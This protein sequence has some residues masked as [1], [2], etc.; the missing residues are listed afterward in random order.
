MRDRVSLASLTVA[1]VVWGGL[2]S[3]SGPPPSIDPPAARGSIAADPKLGPELAY[4]RA[5][6]LQ[7]GGDHL[8]S[9]PYFR[10]ARNAHPEASE[11]HVALAQA[12]HNAAIAT[13]LRFGAVRFKVASSEER[14]LLERE[15][16]SE[17]REA[18]RRAQ[19]PSEYEYATLNLVR[20]LEM[21]GLPADALRELE[22]LK[23]SPHDER[24]Y[25][26]QEARLRGIMS[27]T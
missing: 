25:F 14:L 2:G 12:L 8:A 18:Q 22:A 5:V 9:I 3:C 23:G 27:A 10:I 19:S 13:D 24:A 7:Q 26:A 21:L 17:L 20:T 11:V 16:I 4:E 1:V 6:Q 15:A